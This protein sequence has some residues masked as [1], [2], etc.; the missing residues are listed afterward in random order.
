MNLAVYL[1]SRS[2]LDMEAVLS[3]FTQPENCLET[4]PQRDRG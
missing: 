1:L 3:F 2:Q 4:E